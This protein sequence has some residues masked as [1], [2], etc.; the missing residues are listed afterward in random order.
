MP[1]NGEVGDKV[2][3]QHLSHGPLECPENK[4]YSPR[5]RTQWMRRR[6]WAF[7]QGHCEHSWVERREL[8]FLSDWREWASTNLTPGGRDWR[9][10][11]LQNQ[12]YGGESTY[13]QV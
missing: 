2:L 9:E 7:S 8:G 3:S 12:V 5:G 11:G 6:G 1:E 10:V 13:V 4:T